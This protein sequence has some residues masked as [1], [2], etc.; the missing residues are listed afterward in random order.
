M[1]QGRTRRSVLAGS[2]ALAIGAGLA[3]TT[4]CASSATR[5]GT[6]AQY[7]I[8]VVDTVHAGGRV[9]VAGGPSTLRVEGV[10]PGWQVA[11]GDKVAVGPSPDTAGLTAQPLNH[12]VTYS[13]SAADLV[14][15]HRL[16]GPGGPM[17]IGATR[18]SA[19]LSA[20]RSNGD[21]TVRRLSAAI[22]DRL[23]PD[24]AQR[25]LAIREA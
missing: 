6:D 12:W 8:A 5:P 1:H 22:T 11:V 2:G 10:P 17:M 9:S 16:G 19:S 14:P 24:S 4:A 23:A 25:I 21:R 7:R 18:I 20:Y 3:G 13:A 15:G